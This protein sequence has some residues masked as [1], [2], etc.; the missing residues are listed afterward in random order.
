M[1]K[2]DAA[3]YLR[4]AEAIDSRDCICSCFAVAQ[5]SNY[6]GAAP[7]RYGRRFCPGGWAHDGIWGNEWGDNVR[8]CRILALCFAAAMA[9]SGAL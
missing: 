9:E 8:E 2:K 4:A 6:Q 1:S 3:V 7:S 5:A